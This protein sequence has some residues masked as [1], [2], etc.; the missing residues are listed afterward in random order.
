MLPHTNTFGTSVASFHSQLDDIERQ[1]TQ[2]DATFSRVTL[3]P[4]ERDLEREPEVSR[5]TLTPT[6][7]DPEVSRVTLTPT[8]RDPEFSRVTLT[9]LPQEEEYDDALDGEVNEAKEEKR[10]GPDPFMVVFKPGDR[11]NPKVSHIQLSLPQMLSPLNFRIGA[12]FVDGFSAYC[13]AAHFSG[14]GSPHLPLSSTLACSLFVLNSFVAP[15]LP[16]RQ[17]LLMVCPAYRTFASSSPSGVI[18]PMIEQFKFSE[19]VGILTVSLFVAGAVVFLVATFLP[20]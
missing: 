17:H 6:E 3:T 5:V 19:E 14:L 11:E 20:R 4:T 16:T 13:F 2:G 12:D 1:D 9:P 8:E 10:V 15:F 18:G 7:R